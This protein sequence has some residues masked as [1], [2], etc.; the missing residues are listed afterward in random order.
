MAG[1]HGPGRCGSTADSARL[2]HRGQRPAPP[3]SAPLGPVPLGPVRRGPIR[4]RRGRGSARSGSEQRGW[5]RRRWTLLS[6]VRFSTARPGS[7]QPGLVRCGPPQDSETVS[8]PRRRRARSARRVLQPGGAKRGGR[9][10]GPARGRGGRGSS[11]PCGQGPRLLPH[12]SWSLS[13][14]PHSNSI[15]CDRDP[16]FPG[17]GG[18]RG[19]L[20]S[21]PA[22]AAL[23]P[24]TAGGIH[25]AR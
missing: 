25:G 18:A 19:S 7:V 11:P 23:S 12:N 15:Y 8:A 4:L 14:P 13:S 17:P 9:E 22:N 21:L 20:P 3:G 10:A 5:V 16:P 1:V 6:A 24:S 2:Q